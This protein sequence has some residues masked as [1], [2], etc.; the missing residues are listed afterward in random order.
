MVVVTCIPRVPGLPMSD[1]MRRVGH[2][3]RQWPVS[4]LSDSVLAG[5]Y[6]AEGR[7]RVKV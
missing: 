3:I 2:F 6:P 1:V 5:H 7:G 4:L